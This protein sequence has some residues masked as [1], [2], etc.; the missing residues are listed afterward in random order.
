MTD[1]G[2]CLGK[3][4]IVLDFGDAV[5]IRLSKEETKRLCDQLTIQLLALDERGGNVKPDTKYTY[6]ANIECGLKSGWG[7]ACLDAELRDVLQHY[8]NCRIEVE[9]EHETHC[10]H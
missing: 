8:D 5:S 10:D 7:M 3:D 6:R 9:Y 4:G 1:I 2:T